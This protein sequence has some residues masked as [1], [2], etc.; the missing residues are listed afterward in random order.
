MLALVTTT[1]LSLASPATLKNPPTLLPTSQHLPYQYFASVWTPDNLSLC[2]ASPFSIDR[3]IPAESRLEKG[4][5]VQCR[6]EGEITAMT[7]SA[8]GNIVLGIGRSVIVVDFATGTGQVLKTFESHATTITALAVSNDSALIASASSNGVHI[9]DLLV[10]AKHT[11]LH[12]PTSASRSIS[13]LMFHPHVRTRLL[14][15][16]GC[17][18]LVYD[19]A[20]PS[21]PM[22]TISIGQVVVG[23]ACSPFSKTLVAV[24][25]TSSVNLVDLDK[26]KG[27][28]FIN[29]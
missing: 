7:L 23:I 27:Y 17:D 16:S 2:L 8:S 9:H 21:V 1:A 29:T 10:P 6:E 11:S 25:S 22:K 28:V 26:E 5:Y 19:V 18:I 15:C 12:L 13:T 14:L 3:F 24:A 20:K 4:I